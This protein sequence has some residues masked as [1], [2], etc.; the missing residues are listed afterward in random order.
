MDGLTLSPSTPG[1]QRWR[2]HRKLFMP[3]QSTSLNSACSKQNL[4][5]PVV[6]CLQSTLYSLFAQSLRAIA[7]G[8]MPMRL[9]TTVAHNGCSQRQFSF[10]EQQLNRVNHPLSMRF[11]TA[12]LALTASPL[13]AA[14]SKAA[15]ADDTLTTTKA[16]V[17]HST[18]PNGHQSVSEYMSV[19]AFSAY[20]VH[21]LT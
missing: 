18:S 1:L 13:G 16:H 9:L 8:K 17:T 21:V 14:A 15:G 10:V 19:D 11:Y 2:D 20:V 6:P 3:S 4:L 5:F 7:R 12:L